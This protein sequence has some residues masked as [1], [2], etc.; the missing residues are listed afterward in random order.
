MTEGYDRETEVSTIEPGLIALNTA[1]PFRFP[2]PL[3]ARRH[4]HFQA[5]GTFGVGH[6]PVALMQ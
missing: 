4:S 3:P 5:L 1:N 6:T 2:G